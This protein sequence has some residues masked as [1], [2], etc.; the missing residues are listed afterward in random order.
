MSVRIVLDGFSE[1]SEMLGAMPAAFTDASRSAVQQAADRTEAET[2]AGYPGTG[3]MRAGV[4]QTQEPGGDATFAVVVHSTAPEAHL[5]EYGTE[6][7]STQQGWNRGAEPAHR[8]Q[9]L[10]AIADSHRQ[11]MNASLAAMVSNAGFE[12]TGAF[13]ND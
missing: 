5:W 9:S 6:N 10:I 1:F 3:H 4:K 11:D 7:R 2:I 12:V 8:D 13:D